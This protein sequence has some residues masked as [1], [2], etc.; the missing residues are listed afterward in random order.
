MAFAV[1]SRVR[2]KLVS[3][4]FTGAFGFLQP[5]PPIFGRIT[6]L[7]GTLADILTEDGDVLQVDTT[8][9]EEIQ[10]ATQLTLETWLDKIVVGQLTPVGPR[11]GDGYIGRVAGVFVVAGEGI[12]ILI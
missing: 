10:A 11:F 9:L 12:R 7:A 6:T 5:Q 3:A 2:V 4:A 1:G 8:F